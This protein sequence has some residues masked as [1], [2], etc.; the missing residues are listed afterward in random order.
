[1]A[2]DVWNRQ[3]GIDRGKITVK[4]IDMLDRFY[5]RTGIYKPGETSTHASFMRDMVYGS[6][7]APEIKAQQKVFN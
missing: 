6:Q 3:G 1:M 7:T 4:E 5:T 2:H